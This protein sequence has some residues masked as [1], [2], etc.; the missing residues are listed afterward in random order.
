MNP[1]AP[2]IDPPSDSPHERGII[3]YECPSTHANH[4]S[5]HSNL[6][7]ARRLERFILSTPSAV[8]N[9]YGSLH[10]TIRKL[11][12]LNWLWEWQ[13]PAV[14]RTGTSVRH[15]LWSPICPCVWQICTFGFW[16]I[17]RLTPIRCGQEDKSGSSMVVKGR[18]N[19][20]D[21]E[22]ISEVSRSLA[23]SDSTAGCLFGFTQSPTKLGV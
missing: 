19:W 4:S 13:E 16:E 14:K 18:E 23:T 10:I 6:V 5:I 2:F 15:I 8:S 20:P 11:Y 9:L 21:S 1:A 12:S 17:F 3:F 22:A 7:E